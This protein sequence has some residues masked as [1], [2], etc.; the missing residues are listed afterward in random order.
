MFNKT[1][2]F[3]SS[4]ITSRA[5]KAPASKASPR[6]PSKY[7]ARQF[8]SS[9]AH[10][11]TKEDAI[12]V[13]RRKTSG[14]ASLVTLRRILTKRDAVKIPDKTRPFNSVVKPSV[15]AGNT[16]DGSNPC[17][18]A[19]SC[20]ESRFKIA[21]GLFLGSIASSTRAGESPSPRRYGSSSSLLPP[22]PP[23]LA[24]PSLFLFLDSTWSMSNRIAFCMRI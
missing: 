19:S 12:C 1:I 23:S 20:S 7:I 21:V 3:S 17:I 8:P 9:L 22:P 14:F 16:R 18:C 24:S 13:P 2:S 5:I 11:P 4:G 6:K 10:R 15:S